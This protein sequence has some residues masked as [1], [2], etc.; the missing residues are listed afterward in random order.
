MIAIEH[1]AED[2]Q[3]SEE[4]LEINTGP[5]DLYAVQDALVA[6]G[7]GVALSARARWAAFSARVLVVEATVIAEAARAGET[8]QAFWFSLPA[9]TA[10]CAP[11][12]TLT[13]PQ[14]SLNRTSH[15][16]QVNA[17]TDLAWILGLVAAADVAVQLTMSARQ[18]R[19]AR[20]DVP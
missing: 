2:I 16:E 12:R 20:K 17:G 11:G 6:A 10:A 3:E 18:L 9:A 1:G 14:I 7:Y 15:E 13:P 19:R 8:L 4:G 5:A